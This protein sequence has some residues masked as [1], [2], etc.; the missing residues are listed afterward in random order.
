MMTNSAYSAS[1]DGF[2]H[3]TNKGY[4]TCSVMYIQLHNN[5]NTETKVFLV[6]TILKRK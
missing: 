2:R 1:L 4:I 6:I 3:P 5:L